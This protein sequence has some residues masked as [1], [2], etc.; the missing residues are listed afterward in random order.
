MNIDR[1]DTGPIAYP[2]A[3]YLLAE[4]TTTPPSPAPY[5]GQ[6]N[7]EILCG[8]LGFSKEQLVKL[9]QTGII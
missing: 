6:H 9:Y 3:P 7:E 5:L 4:A 1:T 8:E 2:G